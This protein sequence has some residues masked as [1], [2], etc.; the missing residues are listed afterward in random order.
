MPLSRRYVTYLYISGFAKAHGS[1]SSQEFGC[2]VPI[3]ARDWSHVVTL[4]SALLL[5]FFD[6]A[7]FPAGLEH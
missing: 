4:A 1:M 5:A 3:S 2:M 6:H 7:I